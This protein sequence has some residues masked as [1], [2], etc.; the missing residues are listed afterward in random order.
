ME[1]VLVFQAGTRDVDG[2]LVTSGGRVLNVVGLGANIA[3]AREN[4]Y[5]GAQ[6][7]SFEGMQFRTDIAAQRKEAPE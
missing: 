2:Q 3:E 4:A 5:A 6:K 7:I 1:N